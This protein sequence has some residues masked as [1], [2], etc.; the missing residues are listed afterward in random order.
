MG[1]CNKCSNRNKRNI[2][3]ICHKGD[4]YEEVTS[5]TH[6]D[7]IRKMDDV[8]LSKFIRAIK[9]NTLFGD[10]GYPTCNSMNGTYCFGIEKNTDGD[11]LAWLQE[12]IITEI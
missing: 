8:E 10:C 5:I 6:A 12:K 1:K 2:C 4:C 9:C 11:I 7:R 3:K